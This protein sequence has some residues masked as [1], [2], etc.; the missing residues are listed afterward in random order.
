M[1]Q[2]NNKNHARGIKNRYIVLGAILLMMVVGSCEEPE[3]SSSSSSAP[4]VP[5]PQAVLSWEELYKQEEKLVV[6]FSDPLASYEASKI[7]INKTVK[8]G[9]ASK[10]ALTK[11]YT[12]KL[13]GKTLVITFTKKVEK[14]EMYAVQIQ[15]G[16]VKSTAGKTNERSEDKRVTINKEPE[17]EIGLW[18]IDPAGGKKIIITFNEEIRILDASKIKA[19]K[20]GADSYADIEVSSVAVKEADK[21]QLEIELKEGA[22]AQEKYKVIIEKGGIKGATEGNATRWETGEIEYQQNPLQEQAVYIVGKKITVVFGIALKSIEA[23]KIKVKKKQGENYEEL[24]VSELP[25]INKKINKEQKKHLELELGQAPKQGEVYRISFEAG[26]LTDISN[27]QSGQREPTDKDIE[28]NGGPVL[29]SSKDPYIVGK[30]ITVAFDKELV[31][32][33]TSK[34]KVLKQASG[35]SVFSELDATALPEANKV[36]NGSDKKLL[37]LT[38]SETETIQTGDKYRIKLEAGAVRDTDEGNAEISPTDKDIEIEEKPELSPEGPYIV[39]REITVSFAGAVT[40]LDASKVKVLK[41]SGGASNFTEVSVSSVVLDSNDATQLKVT[42]PATQTGETYRIKLE[43]GAVENGNKKANEELAPTDKD[44]VITGGAVLDTS[45]DPYIVGKEIRV[46]FTKAIAFLDKSKVKV[47]K[48]AVGGSTFSELNASALPE[49]NKVLNS[50]DKKQLELTLVGTVQTGETYRIKLEAGAV[51]SENEGNAEISPTDKDI[52]ITGGPVLDS[53]KDPYIVGK[54]ITVMF[55]RNVEILDKSK[56]QVLK[57]ASGGSSFIALNTTALPEANKVL[58]GS[59]KKLLELTLVGTVQTGDKYRIKLEAGAVRDT[60]EGNT[61]LAPENKDIEITGGPVLDNNQ[62]PY[63]VGKEITVTFDKAIAFLDK[64]KIKVLKQAVGG[65]TFSELNTTALPEAN[66]VLN[67]SNKKLLELTL[68]GTVRTGETYRIKLEAGAILSENEGNAEISPTDKDIVIKENPV[69]N[70]SI[71]PYIVGT[72]IRVIFDRVVSIE[73]KSKIKVQ[74]KASGGTF[75][76]LVVSGSNK[77]LDTDKKILKITIPSPTTGDTYRLELEAGAVS[78]NGRDNEAIAPTD[79]DIVITGG[80]VLDSSKDPYIVG[81]EIRVFFTKAIT[82]L[83]KSKVKVLKQAVGGSSFSELNA[84][85]LPAANKVINSS[86]NKQLELTLVGTVRTG[87]TYRIKLEAGA[88]KDASEGNAEISPTDKDIVISGGPVLDGNV[89]L[90]S[91]VIT[92]TFDRTITIVSKNKIKVLK[93]TTSEVSYKEVSTSELPEANKQRAGGNDKQLKL[94][95]VGTLRNNDSY[96]IALEAG[97]VKDTDEGNGAIAPTD[98]DVVVTGGA[99]LD[100]SKAMSVVGKEFTIPLDKVVSIEDKSKIKLKKQAVGGSAFIDLTDSELPAANKGLVSSN[101]ALKLTVAQ[102]PTKGETYRIELEAGAVKA[103]GDILND[104]IAPTNKDIVISGGPVLDSSNDP[105]IVGAVILVSFDST[106]TIMDKDKIKVQK[107]AS[108]GTFTELDDT[109][110]PDNSIVKDT[111]NEKVLKITVPTPKKNDTYRLEFEAGAVSSGNEGNRTIAPTDKDIVIAG[112]AV[113]DTSKDPYRVGTVIIVSF[114]KNIA[115]L[116]KSKIKVKK[117]AVGGSSYTDVAVSG[118]NIAKDTNDEKVLK[119]TVP[120]PQNKEKY[121]LAFEE[122]ALL[123]GKEGNEAITPTN[124][125]I[126]IGDGPVL[127][128]GTKL[129]VAKKKVLEVSF[130]VEVELI[131]PDSIVVSKKA[132]GGSFSPLGT[133]DRTIAVD[134]TDEKKIQITLT[135]SDLAQDE[136]WKAEF[137]AGTVLGVA[138]RNGNSTNQITG[139]YTIDDIYDLY[140]WK[141]LVTSNE[142]P[143]EKDIWSKRRFHGSVVFKNRI[144][145]LGGDSNGNFLNDVWSSADGQVWKKHTTSNEDKTSTIWSRRREHA[146][147][148]FN[149]RIW[150]M[151]GVKQKPYGPLND[152]WSSA[153]G[154]VWKKHTTSNKNGTNTIWDERGLTAVEFQNKIWII[155]GAADPET[156]NYSDVWSSADGNVWE[157]HSISDSTS[158]DTKLWE[159]SGYP[160]G[161]VVFKSKIWAI[162]GG[163][164]TDFSTNNIWSSDDGIVWKRHTTSSIWRSGSEFDTVVFD[165]KMWVVGGTNTSDV[166][167]SADGEVWKVHSATINHKEIDSY[168]AEVFKNKIFLLGGEIENFKDIDDVWTFPN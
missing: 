167:S 160:Y 154:E 105:Y 21:S 112:G 9:T 101:N 103:A 86:D 49:A 126:T 143:K 53:S 121:R 50:S 148:V 51:L 76:E 5:P 130:P 34:I 163:D 165:N 61:E 54:E 90:A 84:T 145:V 129:K 78:A 139:E 44:I 38:L 31:L 89:S 100:G 83:D 58:N 92:V 97:A 55:D 16:G 13:E 104:T 71:P 152:V 93:K 46:F 52:V 134:S 32:L 27:Q 113:L 7:V 96:R 146:S 74:K 18:Y 70:N 15:A 6:L 25:D 137:P 138:S 37:E 149:S 117:Q 3:S 20:K 144:W 120:T 42:I 82:F 151:G 164:K 140:T 132:K 107:K 22:K 147:V 33:D 41:Q 72:V 125:D 59:N 26:A 11:D 64:S 68:V 124:K 19:Q 10:L 77:E 69:L 111:N 60:D 66:K 12:L 115:F 94:T 168:A 4:P 155:G 106:I 153:D 8:G 47:L 75:T 142:D 166:W 118:S 23:S 122:G 39:G 45:K 62:A 131:A 80:P 30:E 63:I 36:L 81:K 109:A 128:A 29:D 161:V 79:K 17:L 136:T 2:K 119:I 133:S 73:D 85:V 157:E 67:G 116:D 65:S 110:V 91:K 95:L 56:I 48:Q 14:E 98:K 123:S 43:A 1:N 114:D 141:Q 162:G 159:Y 87:E 28:I 156:G 158:D 24:T 57:Q 99:M 35:G 135:K 127:N 150:V 108:G 88:V 40:L 102:T